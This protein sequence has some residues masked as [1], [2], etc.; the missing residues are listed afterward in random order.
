MPSGAIMSRRFRGPTAHLTA[1][2]V[3][4]FASASFAIALAASTLVISAARADAAEVAPAKPAADKATLDKLD[5][6]KRQA[7]ADYAAD[8]LESARLGLREAIT[9][10]GRAGLNTS[11]V[12]AQLWADLGALYINGF[13]DRPKGDK[14][15][16]VAVKIR[17]DVRPSEA[18]LTPEVKAALAALAPAPSPA[19][20]SA[21]PAPTPPIP[22]PLP[23]AGVP[24]AAPVASPVPSTD[25]TPRPAPRKR[26]R[27]TGTEPDL[28]ANFPEPLY[29][30]TVDEAPPDEDVVIHC[31]LGPELDEAKRVILFYRPAGAEGWTSLPTTK[32]ELGWVK[33]VLPS[34][35]LTGKSVQYYLEAR[36][37]TDKPMARAGRDDSP[38]FVLVRAGAASV[39][40]GV[41]AGMQGAR[42]SREGGLGD[43]DP[44]LAVARQREREREA[45]GIHRRGPGTL[46][47]GLSGGTGYGWH[48]TERLEFYDEAEIQAGFIPSGLLHLVPSVGYQLS[49]HVALSLEARVQ[50]IAQTGSG[51]AKPG[52]PARGAFLLL[53][54]AQYLLGQGNFQG[55]MSLLAGAGDG[56]RLTIGPQSDLYRRNDS[57]RGGPLAAGAG[58]GVLYHLSRH[59][60]IVL[61]VRG[62]AGFPTFATVGDLTGGINLSF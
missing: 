38:N 41:W 21:A 34:Q 39:S 52:S 45:T 32:S 27:N 17:P 55:S 43:E 62:L 10:A 25:T 47:F 5:E 60:A 19:A 53:G 12:M 16:A 20:P 22:P 28:P 56:F 31:A 35:A 13:R 50:Y 37:A 30:P 4:V 57:V 23:P 6:L 26:K 40:A 33:A 7:L 44:L 36:D 61:D 51:G 49:D 1:W 15:L 3:R 42:S 8:D 54:R 24:A 48:P 29:C 2:R 9:I 18:M 46:F 11:P 59:F 58:L 14:A